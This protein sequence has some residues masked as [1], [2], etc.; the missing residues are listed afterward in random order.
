MLSFLFVGPISRVGRISRVRD[1]DEAGVQ[2]DVS[3]DEAGTHPSSRGGAKPKLPNPLKFFS[4]GPNNT[5]F[6]F[7]LPLKQNRLSKL[8]SMEIHIMDIINACT[9]HPPPPHPTHKTPSPSCGLCA[10]CR[11]CLRS[12]RVARPACPRDAR[13]SG[14]WATE[15]SARYELPGGA[16]TTACDGYRSSESQIP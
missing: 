1:D 16:N 12:V 8:V 10:V 5:N 11:L 6:L 3:D 13:G 4:R 14:R 2:S 15:A 7:S 9:R